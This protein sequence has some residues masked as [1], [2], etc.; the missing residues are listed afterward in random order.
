MCIYI[1][2]YAYACVCVCIHI[3]IYIYIFIYVYIYIYICKITTL[4]KRA[5]KL[6]RTFISMLKQRTQQ[7][8]LQN[9]EEYFVSIEIQQQT[10]ANS[11]VFHRFR[12]FQG[13]SLPPC[14]VLILLLELVIL[15]ESVILL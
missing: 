9:T 2:I 4:H 11:L 1:Y 6:L 14:Y 7:E 15:L 13:R 10:I 3:Y 5:C 8:S 12:L